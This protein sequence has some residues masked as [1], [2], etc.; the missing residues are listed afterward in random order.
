M[1]KTD[2]WTVFDEVLHEC[3]TMNNA[4][5]SWN[6]RFNATKLPCNNIWN[7]IT[8]LQGEDSLAYERYLQELSKVINPDL[9]PEEGRKRKVKHREKMAKLKNIAERIDEVDATEYLSVVAS[10]IK[11]NNFAEKK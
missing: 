1:F 9:S 11:K 4:L 7:L 5:E 2:M 10:I 3:P 6:G 8:A